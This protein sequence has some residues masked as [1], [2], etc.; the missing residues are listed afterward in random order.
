MI[1]FLFHRKIRI[2][3]SLIYKI[4]FIINIPHVNK[5]YF[6]YPMMIK[7][8]APSNFAFTFPNKATLPSC[9]SS[10]P[11]RSPAPSLPQLLR[12]SQ[13]LPLPSSSTLSALS[14]PPLRAGHPI[15]A[16]VRPMPYLTS[17]MNGHGFLCTQQS[18][19][20]TIMFFLDQY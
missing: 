5:F 18:I 9:L 11:S 16:K 15:L 1:I 19:A 3:I 14:S 20:C 8:D 12:L 6:Y 4:R 7:Y 13:T 17:H 10:P 2:G